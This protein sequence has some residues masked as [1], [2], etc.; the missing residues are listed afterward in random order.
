M[1]D[2]LGRDVPIVAFGDDVTDEDMFEALG[3]H[4]LSVHVGQGDRPSMARARVGDTRAAF[5]VIEALLRSRRGESI[6]PPVLSL[7]TE[8]PHF[9]V[10]VVSNRLPELRTA[11]SGD[12]KKR[13]VGGLVS[14]LEPVLARMKS[15]WLG[16]SG[17]T[18]PGGD[19]L[20]RGIS[21]QG[22]TAFAHFD[23]PE[24]W[25]RRYYNGY[26]NSALWPLLHTF[27]HQ[28]RFA[29]GD[30]EAY[31]NANEAFADAASAI[32]R[33]ESTVWLH[34]YHLFL[35]GA[36]MRRR[37]HT[38]PIG[39]FLH[40]PFCGPDVFFILPEAEKIL[41]G[42]LALDLVGFHT[43]A[44]AENFLRCAATLEGAEVEGNVVRYQGRTT[45]AGV[46]PIGIIPQG[47]QPT[48][49]AATSTEIK[50][51]IEAIRG[52]RLVLGVD[53]LDYTKGIP[54]RL[55]AFGRF[56]TEFPEWR[57]KVSLVQVSVPSRAD[58]PEY[59]EQRSRVEGIVGRVNGEHGDAAWVPIR[60]LYRSYGT[61]ILAE[62][63]RA[64]DVGYVTPLRDGMN[65]VA[66]EYVAAQD[67]ARPGVL[68]LS[69]F[70]GAA[71]ELKSALLTN[72]YDAEGMARDLE[73]ALTMP[74]EER[75]RRHAALLEVV[76][77]TTAMTW[78]E[79]FL[80]ALRG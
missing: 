80:A 51:L 18:V 25:L 52:R 13:N 41:E 37:G 7:E 67:A 10:L 1:R 75:L 56:L 6:D 43:R 38:G 21:Q 8:T 19:R 58:V 12:P 36:G 74:I 16:W 9:D 15:V 23:M 62:L 73:R 54:E 71:A 79:D 65:L 49:D 66:K 53:R 24:K 33:R 76:N 69:R 70:A 39:L 64:A 2:R 4:D 27:P 78:G 20:P 3:P 48:S 17:R 29:S 72:P 45:R 5:G 59:A 63:Y 42:L 50:N 40:V 11:K 61:D 22:P 28:A 68:L 77:R 32:A 55:D 35:V 30:W 34:D 44:Y 47:F 60:Y 31:A 26:S 46:F 57:G 14:A